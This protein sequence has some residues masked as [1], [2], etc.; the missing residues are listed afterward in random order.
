MV[1]EANTVFHMTQ[2]DAAVF[3]SVTQ[4]AFVS[5]F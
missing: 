2:L 1:A 4:H 3:S 5:Q